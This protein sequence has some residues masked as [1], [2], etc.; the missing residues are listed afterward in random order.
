[1]TEQGDAKPSKWRSMRD[2]YWVGALNPKGMVFFAAILPA[3]VDRAR[4]HITQQLIVMGAIFAALA[5]FSDGSWGILA[6]T[7]R[8]WLA[9]EIKR[10][11]VLRRIGGSVM[12]ILGLFTIINAIVGTSR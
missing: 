6:G 4:G 10:L 3:F 12:I 7:L 11:V 8:N 1:M 9:T 5:F 2:G